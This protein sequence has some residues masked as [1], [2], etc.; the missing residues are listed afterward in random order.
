MARA[1]AHT[2]VLV[3]LLAALGLGC[4]KGTKGSSSDGAAVAKRKVAKNKQ[5]A[6][7]A[8]DRGGRERLSHDERKAL[9]EAGGRAGRSGGGF[10]GLSGHEA[11]HAAREAE[12]ARRRQGGGGGLRGHE[13]KHA[14]REA[15]S[16][17]QR[18]RGG[19]D[20][21]LR[22]HE[23]KHAARQAERTQR[24]QRGDGG[25]RPRGHERKHAEREAEEGQQQSPA[26][27][28]RSRG[29][30]HK[31]KE[32]RGKEEDRYAGRGRTSRA[33]YPTQREDD[34]VT[35]PEAAADAERVVREFLKALQAGDTKKMS[36]LITARARGSLGRLRDDELSTTELEEIQGVYAGGT[37]AGSRTTT[38]SSE[39]F[40]VILFP[41]SESRPRKVTVN[42]DGSKWQISYVSGV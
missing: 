18:R 23:K 35:G 40:V 26:G 24:R 3:A 20:G 29:G 34:A 11:K 21:G 41:A 30:G 2:A 36:E 7:K 22:G 33:G 4:S 1:A 6:R 15:E 37:I 9:R 31:G 13:K 38:K 28:G 14:A 10:E 27:G 16:S 39:R 42:H 32:R 25:G 19:G 17:R 5:K 12:R 8:R